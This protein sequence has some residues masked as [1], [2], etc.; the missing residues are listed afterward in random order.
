MLREEESAGVGS[1]T[2]VLASF[3]DYLLAEV[4]QGILTYFGIH[5]LLTERA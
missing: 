2:D 5:E 4:L 1:P 3:E